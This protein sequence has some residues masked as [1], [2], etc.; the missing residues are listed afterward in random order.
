MIL[1]FLRLFPQFRALESD[2]DARLLELRET[3]QEL[4]Q[5]NLLLQD[6][7]DMAMQDRTKLWDLMQ[8][9]IDE[10]R[11]AYQMHINAQWQKEGHGRPYPEAPGLPDYAVPK[12][13]SDPVVPRRMLPS[14]A[15]AAMTR[16]FVEEYAE[17]LK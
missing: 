10:M 15:A 8:K 14:E 7:L 16:R 13:V 17:R 1:R 2:R 9:S 4:Q 5:Q 3:A 12:Q 11:V 6:R